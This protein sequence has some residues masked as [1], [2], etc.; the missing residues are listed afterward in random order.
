[1]VAKF[2]LDPLFNIFNFHSNY[3]IAGILPSHQTIQVLHGWRFDEMVMVSVR[4]ASSILLAIIFVQGYCII[5]LQ[6]AQ[7]SLQVLYNPVFQ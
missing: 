1:M 4:K 5:A 6:L 3:W 7:L 2:V